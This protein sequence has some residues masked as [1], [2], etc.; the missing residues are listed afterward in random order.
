MPT[1]SIPSELLYRTSVLIESFSQIPSAPSFLKDNLFPRVVT[2]SSDLVSV[3]FYR[4]NQR[5][6][7]YCS[8]YSKGT[9]RTARERE[10]SSRSSARPS[11][12]PFAT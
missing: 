4:G 11:S 9:G 2:S 8:R 3:E 10:S 7:P 1:Q 12:S 5:L 6:A